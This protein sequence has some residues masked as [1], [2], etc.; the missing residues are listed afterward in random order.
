MK[1]IH[2]RNQITIRRRNRLKPRPG[3]LSSQSSDPAFIKAAARERDLGINP[4]YL[5]QGARRR[6]PIDA[7]DV[8]QWEAEARLWDRCLADLGT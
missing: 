8:A 4:K 7:R 1:N 5:N 3:P 6:L 2:R